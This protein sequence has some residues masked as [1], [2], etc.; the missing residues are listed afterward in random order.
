MIYILENRKIFPS[1]LQQAKRVSVIS[2]KPFFVNELEASYCPPSCY[3]SLYFMM[4]QTMVR[5]QLLLSFMSYAE[6]LRRSLHSKAVHSPDP[7]SVAQDVS[8][9]TQWPEATESRHIHKTED[10]K[11]FDTLDLRVHSKETQD[12]RRGIRN[13]GKECGLYFLLEEWDRDEQEL[14]LT[15]TTSTQLSGWR[16]LRSPYREY[17]SH[18]EGTTLPLQHQYHPPPPPPSTPNP[19][20]FPSCRSRTLNLLVLSKKKIKDWVG[21]QLTAQLYHQYER[22][23]RETGHWFCMTFSR[24]G[25]GKR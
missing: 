8:W 19:P 13:H 15:S 6:A 18:I 23:A 5:H 12:M 9:S 20:T 14:L 24:W 4:I 3:R 17:D 22:S 2:R 7:V 1:A 16:G 10:C 21:P 11:R 25:P